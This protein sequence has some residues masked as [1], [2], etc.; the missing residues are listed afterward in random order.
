MN[1]ARSSLKL[2]TARTASSVVQFAGLAYFARVLGASPMGVFFLFQALLGMLA[3]P[4]DFGLRSAV[5]KRIS[6]GEAPGRYLSSAVL[7]KFA[8]TAVIV[9]GV[10]LSRPLVNDYLGAE[11]ATLLAVAIVIQDAAKFAIVV[12]KG[13]LRVGETAVLQVARQATWVTVSVVLVTLGFGPASLVYGLLAG[14]GV[15]LVWGWYKVSLV[16]SRPSLRHARSLFDY[17]KHNVVSSVGGYFYNWMDVALIG[18]FLTQ[19]HVGA[20]EMAWRVTSVV[21]LLS[22]S[23]A[24]SIFP[25]VSQWSAEDAREQIEALLPEALTPSLILVIPAFFGTVLLSKEIL[26]LVFGPEYTIATLALVV[27]MFDQVVEGGQVI[28][29]RSLQAVNRPDLAARATVV[30]VVLNL[31]LNLVLIDQF[32]ITG[33]AVATMVASLVSGLLLHTFYLSRLVSI[34]VPYRELGGCVLA[35][36]GMTLLLYVITSKV[37]VDSVLTLVLVIAGGAVSYGAFLF[38]F[39]AIR[40]KVLSASRALLGTRT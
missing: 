12:L 4:A 11:L 36:V 16:P 18:L 31:V 14:F 15:V 20:Y 33:A 1:L 34:R 24:S 19:S 35:A 32:G 7:L 6:E 8:P 21:L 40:R 23:I 10:L 5:E 27:L 28:F 38:V 17:G 30:G 25:Q 2:F 37:A 29:G 3:I 9:A 39:P 22:R 13:E 26:G